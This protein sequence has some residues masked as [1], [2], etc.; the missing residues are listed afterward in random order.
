M[1][2]L[3]FRDSSAKIKT[4]KVYK[5]TKLGS[6]GNQL[7]GIQ[8]KPVFL[9]WELSEEYVILTMA[10]KRNKQGSLR[11]GFVGDFEYKDGYLDDAVIYGAAVESIYK[12]SAPNGS[13][14][15]YGQTYIPK[16]SQGVDWTNT[17]FSSSWMIALSAITKEENLQAD[18]ISCWGGADDCS[19]TDEKSYTNNIRTEGLK[20]PTVEIGGGFNEVRSWMGLNLFPDYWWDQPFQENIL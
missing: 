2:S 4:D 16:D 12:K 18:Y 1:F 3:H 7:K 17:Y 6:F 14:R 8:N 13:K 9:E 10:H 15:F 5:S 20:I 11:F 19:T